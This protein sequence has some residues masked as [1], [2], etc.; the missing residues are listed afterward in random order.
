MHHFEALPAS[1]PFIVV[2]NHPSHYDLFLV[3]AFIG[4]ILRK[5]RE[6]HRLPVC[7]VWDGVFNMPIVGNVLK[8]IPCVPIGN[9]GGSRMVA[10]RKMIRHVKEGRCVALAAEGKCED[11]FGNFE[12]GAA[13][14]S[15]HT[16]V[17]IVPITICGARGL[18]NEISWPNRF[19]GNA[20]VVI[21]PPLYPE[22]FRALNVSRDEALAKFTEAMRE[23]VASALDY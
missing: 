4:N 12:M 2:T 23:R 11:A 10:L 22:V 17:P 13:F 6:R 9:E 16:G 1:R 5:R 21:H 15:W 18:Y 8:A 7:G 20:E 14:I 3:L 19:W